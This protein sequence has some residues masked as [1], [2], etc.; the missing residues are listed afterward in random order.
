L[1]G[2]LAGVRRLA[3]L[4]IVLL[5]LSAVSG[6]RGSDGCAM[7]SGPCRCA[8][9]AA[10]GRC[11]LTSG[12]CGSPADTSVAAPATLAVLPAPV[13]AIVDDEA[14]ATR[15]RDGDAPG[16]PAR[17]PLDHPPQSLS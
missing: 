13:P 10:A 3:A 6:W 4:L 8:C 2:K 17:T 12:G 7:C 1:R 11:A 16:G 14:H 15:P 5:Y 9:A